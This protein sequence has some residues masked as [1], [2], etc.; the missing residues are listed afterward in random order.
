MASS[1][2]IAY[3]NATSN[4]YMYIRVS[5]WTSPAL[6]FQCARARY[7]NNIANSKYAEVFQ[8]YKMYIPGDVPVTSGARAGT[9]MVLTPALEEFIYKIIII[10]TFLGT[11]SLTT[12][13]NSPHIV[14]LLMDIISLIETKSVVIPYTRQ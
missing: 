8:I 5:G 4:C 9:G 14:Q 2:E 11:E 10:S 7:D 1:A 3:E 13:I 12:M 6:D